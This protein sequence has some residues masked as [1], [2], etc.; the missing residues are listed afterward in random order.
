MEI[1]RSGRNRDAWS[2]LSN[3]LRG[4]Q[5][6]VIIFGSEI[7]GEAIASLVNFGSTI[8]GAKFLCLG[9]YANSRGAA[10]MGFIRTCCPAITALPMQG[11]FRESGATSLTPGLTLPE[12]VGDAQ[13]GNLKLFMLSARIRVTPWH[14]DPSAFPNALSLCRTCS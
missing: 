5:N 4:E 7:R 10:D 6:L 11:P 2:G 1:A 12:M 8:D 14:I 3:K 13:S 9:D